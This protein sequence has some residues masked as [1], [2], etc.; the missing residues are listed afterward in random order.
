MNIDKASIF[1]QLFELWN[2]CK[3]LSEFQTRFNQPLLP[4]IDPCR[5]L[6]AFVLTMNLS[7]VLLYLDP[8]VWFHALES[9]VEKPTKVL[10]TARCASSVNVIKVFVRSPVPSHIGLESERTSK[11]QSW[12]RDSFQGLPFAPHRLKPIQAI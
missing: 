9:L 12:K 3:R 5:V 10:H 11:P 7:L 4:W 8:S 1:H 2:T 6:H